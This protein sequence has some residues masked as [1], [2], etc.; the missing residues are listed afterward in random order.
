MKLQD[1]FFEDFDISDDRIL[2]ITLDVFDLI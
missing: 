2:E 1:C